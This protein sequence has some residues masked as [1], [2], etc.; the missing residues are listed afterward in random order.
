[1]D[2]NEILERILIAVVIILVVVVAYL[3]VEDKI[4]SE[5]T[6]Q[7]VSTNRIADDI[8]YMELQIADNEAGEVRYK[9]AVTIS[10]KSKINTLEDMINASEKYEF[11][12]SMGFDSIPIAHLY[13]NNG[14]K[15]EI[16]AIDNYFEDGKNGNFIL[17]TT[18]KSEIKRVYKVREE[19]GKHIENM[20]NE[21]YNNELILYY[22]YELSTK[23]GTQVLSDMPLNDK[24]TE[25]FYTTYYEYNKNEELGA[26]E[27]NSHVETYEDYF[28]IEGIDK[29]AI[30]AEYNPIPR[31]S[32]GLEN[33]PK[34]IQDT[35]KDFENIEVEEIDLDGNEE[36][37]YIVVASKGEVEG[38]EIVSKIMLYNS[39][40]KQISTLVSWDAS[41]ETA[42]S[43]ELV[44]KLDNVMC[45]DINNDNIMEILVDIPSYEG[46]KVGLYKYYD[47]V[48]Y[49][50]IDYQ[51][52]IKP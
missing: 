31:V 33:V 43:D 19:V 52:T 26:L 51:A 8:E 1:M 38:D 22:G 5:K 49:G 16:A 10:D 27:V 44:L 34:E 21:A 6:Q 36:L 9:P 20:Y 48:L 25:R 18:N 3:V 4:K 28:I 41:E 39:N 15:I 35:L 40:F 46:Q 45:F 12:G 23:T 47:K 29:I 42:Y 30:S 32:N 7:V 17:Y 2:R 50:D 14:E 37:E 24:I 11:K 13:K